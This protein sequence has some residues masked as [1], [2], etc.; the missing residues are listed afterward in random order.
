MWKIVQD[1][2][3]RVKNRNYETIFTLANGYRGFRGYNEFSMFRDKGNYIA[4]IFDKSTAQVPE[5]VNFPDPLEVNFYL[6]NTKLSV[7]DLE[8]K[9]FTRTL[10]MKNSVLITEVEFKI[11]EKKHI[12]IKAERF[13]SR[14]NIHRYG[15]RYIISGNFEGKLLVEN[16][17]DGRTTNGTF[18][19]INRVRHYNIIEK[20]N[21]S[22]GLLMV[23]KTKDSG[24]T[25]VEANN[26]LIFSNNDN[27]AK[28]RRYE[29]FG[30]YIREI[31]EVFMM[32]GKNYICIKY[33]V[34]YTSRE[35][36]DPV[37]EALVDLEEFI[38]EGFDIELERHKEIQKK[39]WEKINVKIE[40]DEL[41]DKALRFNLFHLAS[42]GSE[43]DAKVSI[44]AKGLHGEG[45]KGHV[46]WDTETF[47]FP[48]F[49]YTQPCIAKNL[50]M[51]RY[52]TLEGARENAFENGYSGAQFPWESAEDGREVTPKWGLDY[53]GN[54]VRIWTG[55]EEYHINSDIAVAIFDY[56]R[57]TGDEDFMINYGIELLADTAKFWA[58]RV[59]YNQKFDRYEINRVIGPDEFHEHVNNN[60]Y[61]NYL[62]K[63]H[64]S[65]AYEFLKWLEK[66]SP[67]KFVKL[68]TGLGIS[69][70][71]INEWLEISKKIYIPKR[72]DSSLIEQFEG[73]FKLKDYVITEYDENG[74]P[75]WPKGVNLSKLNETKLIKQPDV[76]MLMLLLQEEFT[77]EEKRV[78]YEYYEKRTMH[79][80]SLSPSIYSIMGIKVGDT[81]NAYKYFMKTVLVDLENN[82]GNTELG[83]H[84]ASAGGAWQAAVF[85]FGGLSVDKNGML[86]FDPWL[87]EHWQSL[88]YKIFWKGLQMVITVKK[89]KIIITYGKEIEVFVKGRKVRILPASENVFPLEN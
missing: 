41:A 77:L 36:E 49:L 17:I 23:S 11:S 31:Y 65:K 8:F 73:Y 75:K 22:P 14:N 21:M 63:W 29:E 27:V 68:I 28:N 3:D 69:K 60:V 85:G 62:A 78:N 2:Y 4:G 39:I 25:V 12:R 56:Y 61:T 79:K 43:Y 7:D 58:S 89:E 46:F 5:L 45:Y 15:V 13:V 88:S 24:I 38:L 10:D 35:I 47:M 26:L 83:L 33:G 51:Y 20:R 74:M 16:V 82:Q 52:N 19:P 67:E 80:S 66:R 44:G 53:Y 72:E 70:S 34:T 18:D 30:D 40:G 64:L 50:L 32:P 57:A 48:F 84:A 1:S 87:P 81:H 6:D 42:C 76:I 54:H 59:E 55:D 86:H 9:Y 37:K 71:D